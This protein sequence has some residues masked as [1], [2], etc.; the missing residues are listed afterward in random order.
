MNV[1]LISH[2]SDVD[3]IFSAAIALQRYPQAKVVFT[4]YG[5]ENFS[6]VCDIVYREVLSHAGNGLLVFTDLGLNEDLIEIVSDLFDFIES[7]RWD[8]IWIDHHPWPNKS[9]EFFKSKD[10]SRKLIL[11]TSGRKC[12]AD[13]VYEYM[14][15]D[16][17]K[18]MLLA[19]IAHT[20]DFLLKDQ[21]YPPL[22]ELIVYYKNISNFYSKLTELAGKISEGILWD[23]TMQQEFIEYV[24]LRDEAKIEAMKK[25]QTVVI[26]KGIKMVVIPTSPYIQ[27]SL[28][29]DEIFEDSDL[30]VIFLLSEEG[31]VSIR[32][33]NPEIKCNKIASALLEGG[34]HEYAAGGHIKSNPANLSDVISELRIAT[35]LSLI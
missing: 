19:S 30:D 12:A 3:G 17:A 29:S 1:I 27:A 5:K 35:E 25:M 20:S 14:L 18:A 31:K 2:E 23:T 9:L 13:L 15:N 33:R 24:K 32:R 4:S 16:N 21:N 28:F 8:I 11:D 10:K 7:N 34:G 26:N 22:P 6:R